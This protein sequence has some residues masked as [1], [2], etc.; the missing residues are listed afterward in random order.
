[1][2]MCFT[3]RTLERS[4]PWSATSTNRFIFFTIS[5]QHQCGCHTFWQTGLDEWRVYIYMCVGAWVQVCMLIYPRI[6]NPGPP[7]WG[8]HAAIFPKEHIFEELVLTCTSPLKLFHIYIYIYIY[9]YRLVPGPGT[10][11]DGVGGWGGM[12]TFMWTCRS[13]WCY[14]HAGWGGVGC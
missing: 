2:R 3:F 10:T 14:A 7:S 12:L 9:V 4:L 6:D 13:S 11:Y 1:M 5:G 8:C